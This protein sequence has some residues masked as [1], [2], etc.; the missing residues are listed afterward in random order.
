MSSSYSSLFNLYAL[1]MGRILFSLSVLRPLAVAAADAKLI[2]R[3]DAAVSLAGATF[4]LEAEWATQRKVATSARGRASKIDPAVDRLVTA[5]SET[6]QNPIRSLPEG[7]ELRKLA[8]GFVDRYF[9]NGAVAITTLPYDEELVR[10]EWLHTH[11][12]ATGAE[13]ATLGLTPYLAE[14][15][16]VLP[17]YRAELEILRPKGIRYDDLQAERKRSNE[18]LLRV[19]ARVADEW[20]DDDQAEIRESLL[21]PILA[22]NDRIG[23]AYRSRVAP[24]DVDPQT[25]VETDAAAEA[26]A[27]TG[28]PD[29]AE[30]ALPIN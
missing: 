14:L 29:E 10:V 19:V 17:Q 21:A 20:G 3:I 30:T 16:S 5:L 12:T 4:Q 6:L 9:P 26:A 2:A 7:H 27:T 11:L 25:G 15:A 24:K 18:A 1:P 22:Q 23:D 28:A 13:A 8:Q